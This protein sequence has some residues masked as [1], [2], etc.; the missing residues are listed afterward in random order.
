MRLEFAAACFFQP[1]KFTALILCI[2]ILSAGC[3]SDELAGLTT[4]DASAT[5]ATAL[6]VNEA[7]AEAEAA[8]LAAPSGIPSENL[9]RELAS[10]MATTDGKLEQSFTKL[11]NT[12]LAADYLNQE[13]G[14]LLAVDALSDNYL[15]DFD[16][17]LKK[18]VADSSSVQ[19]NFLQNES[20]AKLMAAHRIQVEAEKRLSYFL[21]RAL[22]TKWSENVRPEYKQAAIQL[23]DHFKF[24][25]QRRRS[26]FASPEL[27]R[28]ADN[29]LN[30]QA[31]A[32][33]AYQ[34]Q[35]LTPP[36]AKVAMDL[37]FVLVELK[38]KANGSYSAERDRK[39]AAAISATTEIET[40]Q[41]EIQESWLAY[42]QPVEVATATDNPDL[43]K[44]VEPSAGPSGSVTGASFRN[45]SWA[46]TYE[47]GPTPDDEKLL[48]ILSSSN[49]KATFF[50]N[51]EPLTSH[52]GEIQ[53]AK[54]AGMTLATQSFTGFDLS[55]A[56]VSTEKIQHEINDAVLLATQAFGERPLLFRCPY[57][58][59]A[60]VDEV[61]TTFET[62]K[63]V[64]VLWNVDGIMWKHQS[65]QK[66]YDR[67]RVQM[68]VANH[69]IITLQDSDPQAAEVTAKLIK[70]FTASP[71]LHLITV[72]ENIDQLNHAIARTDK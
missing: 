1:L 52:K 65:P 39:T 40:I 18:A 16:L 66:I 24:S 71:K 61:R 54:A 33:A 69:G 22:E 42:P 25:L 3:A 51:A 28:L 17:R 11:M 7:K 62:Q 64:Q 5:D 70:Y 12:P 41:K 59:C 9:P 6:A 38:A 47:G 15:V 53:K 60:S 19:P 4:R 13:I 34:Q 72:Q 49:S 57:A 27:Q 68:D 44:K 46:L 36:E 63:L 14:R 55:P 29:F 2:G 21:F 56:A 31:V 58:S 67:I 45:D 48:A 20:Y 50:W 23:V 32:R 10:S 8:K 26:E 30:S 35:S 37:N 43:S